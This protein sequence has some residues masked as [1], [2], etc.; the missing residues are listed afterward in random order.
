[1]SIEALGILG[2]M[3]AGVISITMY[4]IASDMEQR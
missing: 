4:I 2:T 3:I 1:M